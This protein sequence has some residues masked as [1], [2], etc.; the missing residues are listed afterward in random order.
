V[1]GAAPPEPRL[2]KLSPDVAAGAD[3]RQSIGYLLRLALRAVTQA[4]ESRTIVHGVSSGQWYFLRELWREDG[5]TQR[6]LSLRVGMREPTTVVAVTKLVKA[7][8]VRRAPDAN[9][10]RKARIQL[11]RKGR[12]LAPILLPLVTEV[13]A[14]ATAGLTAEEIDGLRKSLRRVCENFSL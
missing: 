2:A 13:N 3:P 5:L 4:L 10:R 12:D 9:D 6:E 8:F 11:T 14:L 1:G 7:G